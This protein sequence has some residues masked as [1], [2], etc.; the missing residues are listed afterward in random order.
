MKSKLRPGNVVGRGRAEMPGCTAT[1]PA[2]VDW[3]LRAQNGDS[4]MGRARPRVPSERTVQG[5]GW[6]GSEAHTSAARTVYQ[7][8][9][10]CRP[11]LHEACVLIRPWGR[12]GGQG[13]VPG[14]GPRTG[15]PP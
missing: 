3:P 6:S 1:Q 8:A 14:P 5:G 10:E 13:E 2:E 7:E 12:R 4:E 9:S 11:S 15:D